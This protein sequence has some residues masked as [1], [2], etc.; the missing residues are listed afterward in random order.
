MKDS[1][2]TEAVPSGPVTDREA[3]VLVKET[4]GWK[5]TGVFPILEVCPLAAAEEEKERMAMPTL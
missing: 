1:S 3:G 4:E 2:G 5:F